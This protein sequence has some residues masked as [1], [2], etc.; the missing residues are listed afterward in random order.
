MSSYGICHESA[1]AANAPEKMPIIMSMDSPRI[2]GEREGILTFRWGKRCSPVC[3][4]GVDLALWYGGER[5]CGDGQLGGECHRKVL[6]MCE[7]LLE[8]PL[9][10]IQRRRAV[11][12]ENLRINRDHTGQANTCT[13]FCK[14]IIVSVEWQSLG[15]KYSQR[16]FFRFQVAGHCSCHYSS[17]GQEMSREKV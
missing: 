6:P 13:R 3:V 16:L 9:V 11:L 10:G 12:K 7:G 14:K 4:A 1:Y 8:E 15:T 17:S 5:Q 2:E